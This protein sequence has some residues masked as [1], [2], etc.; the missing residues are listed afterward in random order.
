[1]HHALPRY[2]HSPSA[3]SGAATKTLLR[4]SFAFFLA[5]KKAN[6]TATTKLAPPQNSQ[7]YSKRHEFYVFLFSGVPSLTVPG[8]AASG[9]LSGAMI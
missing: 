8:L 1:L 4:N 6:R 7:G 2:I 5:E 9:C 3:S